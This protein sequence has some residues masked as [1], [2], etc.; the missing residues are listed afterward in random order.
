MNNFHLNENL[1]H[2]HG[3]D[4]EWS[5]RVRTKYK[6]KFNKHSNVKLLK[7]KQKYKQIVIYITMQQQSFYPHEKNSIVRSK[8]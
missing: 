7:Y 2:Y 5:Q 4:V 1:L 8:Q 6:F 3:E